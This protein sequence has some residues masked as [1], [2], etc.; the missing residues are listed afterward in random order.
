M[1][2]AGEIDPQSQS[3]HAPAQKIHARGHHCGRGQRVVRQG[4]GEVN[5][6]PFSRECVW[7]QQ[8]V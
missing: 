2:R 6:R 5:P 3:P 1:A 4:K 7:G 8:G